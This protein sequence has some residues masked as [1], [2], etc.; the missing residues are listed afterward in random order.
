MKHIKKTVVL[1]LVAILLAT[2]LLTGCTGKK[3]TY[4]DDA[5]RTS[6]ET[7]AKERV[8]AE[9][10]NNY[11]TFKITKES[12]DLVIDSVTNDESTWTANGT[13]TVVNRSD[14]DN[15]QTVN[16]MISF[17]LIDYVGQPTPTF[18]LI[19]FSMDEIIVP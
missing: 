16:Y 8:K 7:A 1:L 13:V 2:T 15:V 9:I 6:A 11:K 14:K 18:K 12:E 4:T 17:E 5:L 10:S 3:T 19:E